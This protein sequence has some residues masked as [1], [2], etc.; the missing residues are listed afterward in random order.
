MKIYSSSLFPFIYL[1][2]L[3]SD[4]ALEFYFFFHYI[5]EHSSIDVCVVDKFVVLWRI[6]YWR[7]WCNV[8]EYKITWTNV[9]SPPISRSIFIFCFLFIFHKCLRISFTSSIWLWFPVWD[10]GS[11]RNI[12]SFS[13][14]FLILNRFF[15]SQEL[16]AWLGNDVNDFVVVVVWKMQSRINLK[17]TTNHI[18]KNRQIL[19]W[20]N[21]YYWRECAQNK[22]FGEA[23]SS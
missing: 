15:E 18:S 5:M 11:L 10:M 4:F 23:M 3:S 22:I 20:T 13:F 9:T 7:W 8:I 2:F 17:P 14:C 6:P 1:R 21:Y 19:L 12:F 16:S